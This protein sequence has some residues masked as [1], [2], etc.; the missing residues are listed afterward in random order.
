VSICQDDGSIRQVAVAHKDPTKVALA[1]EL[2]QRYPIDMSAPVGLPN[3]LRTGQSEFYPAITPEMAKAAAHDAQ[4]LQIILD[5]QMNS[6]M[7]VPLIARGQCFG[8]ITFVWAESGHYYSVTDLALAEELAHR[9]AISVDNA[10]LYAAEQRNR[11]AT[12]R[13]ATRITSLQSVTAALSGALTSMQVAEVVIEYGLAVSGAKSGV[14][15]L[16]DE[17]GENLEIL[18]YFGY[19]DQQVK[20]W[21]KFPLSASVPVAEAVR[22]GTSIYVESQEKLAELYPELY[23][24]SKYRA[25]V[26]LPLVVEDKTIGGIGLSFA[27]AQSFSEEDRSFLLSLARLCAQALER[28]HLYELEK[29]ARTE[30][31]AA[32]QRLTLLAET[33]ERNRLAQD[34]H[35]NI[36]QTL[37]YLNLQITIVNNQLNKGQLA[38]VQNKLE[39]LKQV[40]NE[41]YTDV[42][43]EIFNLR[44]RI[45]AELPF[46]ETLRSYLSKYKKFYKLD[47][48]L[49]LEADE[50]IFTFSSEVGAQIIR[51]IQ[52]A[53]INVRKH[54]QTDQA[55][56][57]LS[58][59][60]DHIRISIEDQGEGFNLEEM[61][62][63][64][65]SFGLKIIQ[66]R[67]ERIG[68]PLKINS[69]PG[70]GTT[71]ILYYSLG[72]EK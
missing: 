31:E 66:E 1:Y 39:E 19:S 67:A 42:R 11:R 10:R 50:A 23:P 25:S 12:E 7:I 14:I 40:V 62:E 65:N 32:Q 29:K 45:T 27:E 4:H 18:H 8:A 26:S 48:Q 72:N 36:A 60:E 9:A 34:L 37:G 16:L 15:F 69:I 59:Q 3:V 46:L 20:N 44:A 71:I 22:T 47:V 52:E 13:I 51:I 41:A 33:Q 68:S 56:I 2:Q 58:Q 43:E 5:L 55:T 49:L 61:L 38:E 63:K 70:E 57:R 6:V 54:A 64:G 30:A 24:T 28:A 21:L 35:D 53:L 17:P